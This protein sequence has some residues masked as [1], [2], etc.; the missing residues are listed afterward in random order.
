MPRLLL[1]DDEENVLLGMRRYFAAS[2]F[3]VDCALE[4][5]E[6]EALVRNVA[7][8]GVVLDLGLTPGHGPDGLAVIASTR[9]HCPSARI[10][11]LTAVGAIETHEQALWLGADR[12]M[13]KPQ[14]LPVLLAELEK[15]LGTR[16]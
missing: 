3:E 11:V 6:A 5:E 7:Y 1:V 9:E 10:L 8:D 12:Y 15:L 13:Q 4:R 16:S 14:P 2:G